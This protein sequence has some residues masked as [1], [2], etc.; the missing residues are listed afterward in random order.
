MRFWRLTAG[1]VLALPWLATAQVA[2]LQ[3][4]IIEGEGGVHAPGSRSPRP[5]TVTVTDETGRPVERAAVSFHMPDE[6][7][8]G[9]FANGLRTIV[10]MTD[11]QG[12]ASAHGM[13]WNRL[14]GRFQIR[15][16]ASK[17]QGRAGTVSF[18]YI[19][20]SG[21]AATAHASPGGHR[22]LWI[23]AA[24]VAGGAA[25]GVVAAGRSGTAPVSA[26]AVPSAPAA[27]TAVTIGTPVITVGKP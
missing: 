12:Q 24:L 27:I 18:Q 2:I 5:L 3:I 8:G 21:T 1:L 26:A 13:Q 22:T 17:E 16:T 15:I 25:T 23:V 11:G 19:S 7:P 4:R 6:G 20:G 10:V 9:T 14:A